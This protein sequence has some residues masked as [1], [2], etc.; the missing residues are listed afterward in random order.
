MFESIQAL[1]QREEGAGAACLI[2]G[3]EGETSPVPP[4]GFCTETI[5]CEPDKVKEIVDGGFKG[6][7]IIGPGALHSLDLASLAAV[8]GIETL[9]APQRSVA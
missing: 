3:R 1:L 2:V 4:M 7:I 6:R 9:F 5:H 8:T